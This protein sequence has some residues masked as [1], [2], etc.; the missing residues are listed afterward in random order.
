MKKKHI[1]SVGLL[2]TA[3][4]AQTTVTSP[5]IAADP[6]A[7]PAI[8]QKNDVLTMGATSAERYFTWYADSDAPGKFIYEE[9]TE[10]NPSGEF[11]SKAKTLE[12]APSTTGNDE[13]Q[14][15][16][17]VHLEGLKPNTTY[18]Y[19]YANGDTESD[20]YTFT[21]G[22]DTDYSFF[23][24][25]DPQIG[26]G[27]HLHG[28]EGWEFTLSQMKTLDANADFLLSAG[29]NVNADNVNKV[30]PG[31]DEYLEEEQEYNTFLEPDEF[32]GLTFSTTPGNH[33]VRSSRFNEHFQVPNE[34]TDADTTKSGIGDSYYV[35]NNTLFLV[36]N[37]NAMSTAAHKAFMEKAIEE[38]KDQDFDW[39]V[40]VFHHAPY[41]SAS[42]STDEDILQ[43]R[44]ELAP[45]MKEL[46]IDLVL[47]GHD[48]VYDRTFV[49]GGEDG[50]TPL[51]EEGKDF[52]TVKPGTNNPGDEGFD[53]LKGNNSG[54]E[55]IY[56][57]PKGVV[58][59]TANSASGSKFYKIQKTY[60]YARV[61]N[62]EQVP[63]ITHIEVNDKEGTLTATTY[64]SRND[65]DITS[66]DAIVDKVTIEKD[67]AK[68]GD[69]EHWADAAI[70][71]VLDK[72]LMDTIEGNFKPD[73]ATDRITVV[74]A[75]ARMEGV[76]LDDYRNKNTLSDLKAA[77]DD[78]AIVNWAME[79]GI[80]HGYEDGSFRPE[81]SI[82]REEMAK[83]L[84]T[85]K[86][87][88][89]LATEKNEA[90]NYSDA[91]QIAD[92]AKPYVDEATETGLLNG[93]ASGAFGPKDNL[94]RA[95]VAQIVVNILDLK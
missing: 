66:D 76:N 40:V 24:V 20:V 54:G 44:N 89:S 31:S 83:V 55:D 43:R 84:V 69:G 53:M 64:R 33:D 22:G 25:G 61:S 68:D 48:H 14:Y 65:I 8:V 86:R 46:G 3:M 34:S 77:S 7:A 30:K 16:N 67:S 5:V 18:K 32:R 85:Y 59:I 29:D 63:N 90:K 11:S 93:H 92:W 79:Q 87:A 42:H 27:G 95:E 56:K 23:F 52:E 19:T 57:N 1:L 21:T 51:T 15:I 17:R 35:Y 82:S 50:T 94:K 10:K 70:Q 71:T 36:L 91:A 12:S 45:V 80:I 73:T 4:L 75:L 9:T 49:M 88:T 78:A 26:S 37:S 38:T 6:G 81:R 72:K 28:K 13:G 41:S 62:Q 39:K 47:N 74:K 58:Y 2:A 60:D